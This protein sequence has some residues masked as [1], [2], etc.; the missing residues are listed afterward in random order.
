LRT[1]TPPTPQASPS[2]SLRA[3]A[4]PKKAEKSATQMGTD[5]SSTA[6]TPEE[7]HCSATQTKALDEQRQRPM[8]NDPRHC[9]HVGRASPRARSTAKSTAPALKKRSAASRN[10][11]KSCSAKRM[12]RK[13]D[14]QMT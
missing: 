14:P 13:V 8:A 6:A 3:G 1:T 12:P 10:G 11:G 4:L 2:H 7:T 9:A 5:P